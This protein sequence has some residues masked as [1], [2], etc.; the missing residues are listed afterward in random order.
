M[1]RPFPSP[2]TGYADTGLEWVTP[3][4]FRKTVATHLDREG[5]GDA[6]TLQLGH[7]NEEVTKEYYIV[8]ATAA[9]DV[10][11]VLDKLGPRS[12]DGGST[13]V[14]PAATFVRAEHSYGSRRRGRRV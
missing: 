3:H 14:R 9:P 6:A 10:T 7:S 13:P 4:I 8:T 5:K 12:P 2:E 1:P 11:D